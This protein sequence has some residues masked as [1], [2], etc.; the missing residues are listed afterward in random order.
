MAMNLH[1]SDKLI[2]YLN[3][4]DIVKKEQNEIKKRLV[5]IGI[6]RK[7]EKSF[8]LQAVAPPFQPRKQHYL[9]S[10]NCLSH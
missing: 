2:Y 10:Q 9:K 6:R 4:G 3:P 7:G 8:T 1:I 5:G